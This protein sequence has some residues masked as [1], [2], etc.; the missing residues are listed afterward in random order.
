MIILALTHEAPLNFSES[1]ARLFTFSNAVF[2]LDSLNRVICQG[3]G[4]QY[5]P[6]ALLEINIVCGSYFGMPHVGATQLLMVGKN[7]IGTSV[8]SL[9]CSSIVKTDEW[10]KVVLWR[11]M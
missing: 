11:I 3:S 1:G 10:S 9:K 7:E 6:K 8:K 2:A 4:V 5:S